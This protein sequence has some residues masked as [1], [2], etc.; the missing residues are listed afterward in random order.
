MQIGHIYLDK[1]LISEQLVLMLWLIFFKFIESGQRRI[2]MATSSIVSVKVSF[3]DEIFRLKKKS[4]GNLLVN[5]IK[6]CLNT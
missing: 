1:R 5:Q 3:G 2:E 4:A 6:L